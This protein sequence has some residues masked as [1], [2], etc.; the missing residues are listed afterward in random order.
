LDESEE[1]R[2]DDDPSLKVKQV[3]PKRSAKKSTAKAIP[4]TSAKLQETGESVEGVDESEA[5]QPADDNRRKTQ[6]GKKEK[7]MQPTRKEMDTPPSPVDG[8]P[9]S[10][11]K[12]FAVEIDSEEKRKGRPKSKSTR[13]RSR[14]RSKSKPRSTGRNTSSKP[15][16]SD[17][18]SRAPSRASSRPK[19]SE[20]VEVDDENEDVGEHRRS[21]SPPPKSMSTAKSKKT[22]TKADRTERTDVKRLDG[23]DDE[24]F[25]P[26]VDNALPPDRQPPSP[27]LDKPTYLTNEPEFSAAGTAPHDDSLPTTAKSKSKSKRSEK[28]NSEVTKPPSRSGSKASRSRTATA[29]SQEEQR[30]RSDAMEVDDQQFNDFH[31]ETNTIDDISAAK[32]KQECPVIPKSTSEKQVEHLLFPSSSSQDSQKRIIS[33]KSK[34]ISRRMA[35]AAVDEARERSHSPSRTA[36]DADIEMGDEPGHLQYSPQISGK[37]NNSQGKAPSDPQSKVVQATPS[38]PERQV[39]RA[40]SPPHTSHQTTQPHTTN[41]NASPVREDA[42]SPSPPFYPP[43]SDTPLVHVTELSAEERELTVE[44]WVRHE[45][46]IQCNKLRGDAEGKIH[47]LKRRAEEVRQ[48]IEAL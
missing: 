44:Q 36:R 3:P 32:S 29:A 41:R 39:F 45:M 26:V 48:I 34:P 33:A 7:E 37:E 9:A 17:S 8:K 40:N 30:P 15:A 1:L 6:A 42:R 18:E 22:K 31:P 23:G 25:R 20:I 14:S 21:P 12:D 5:K 13:T 4:A 19:V 38:T 2:E 46:E 16:S 43:L 35:L 27:S 10:R 28:P 11:Y 24:D 47:L